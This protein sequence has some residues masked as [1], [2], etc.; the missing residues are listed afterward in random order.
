MLLQSVLIFV[1]VLRYTITKLRNMGCAAFLPLD[2]NIYIH[3]VVGITI[4]VYAWIHSIMHV[5]N[6]CKRNYLILS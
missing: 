5:L 3:K 1:L 6:F 2:H 4:F